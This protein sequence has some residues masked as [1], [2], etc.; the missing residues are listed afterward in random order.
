MATSLRK[1]KI[2]GIALADE[3]PITNPQG[4]SAVYS[5][6]F[7][8]SATLSDFTIYFLEM[9][10]IPGPNGAIAKQELKAIVT[11]PF[12]AAAGMMQ[13]LQQTLQQHA[14]QMAEI[15]KQMGSGK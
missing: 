4:L 6:H 7:G 11:L 13:V 2:K 15:Q 10:Q 5:N 9:G 1:Q 12:V 3:V 8:M 14:Q